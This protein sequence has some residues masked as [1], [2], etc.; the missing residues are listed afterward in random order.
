MQW[1][2]GDT[3]TIFET[4]E[5]GDNPFY[6]DYQVL[7]PSFAAIS[8]L[9][10]VEDVL[11]IIV[12]A[13]G[14][15]AHIRFTIV[16]WGH[17]FNMDPRALPFIEVDRNDVIQGIYSVSEEQLRAFARL[18][19]KKSYK[20]II[21]MS[22]DDVLLT[23]ADLEPLRRQ[24]EE[25]LRISTA[26]LEVSPLSGTNQ[27]V[28][29]DKALNLLYQPFLSEPIEKKEGI[30]IVGWKWPSRERKFDIGACLSLLIEIGVK[31]NYVIPGGSKVEDFR[32][33]LS[34]Q[35]NL[36]WCPAYIGETL[37]SLEREKGIPIAG[38]TPPYG[39]EGTMQWITELAD[40]LNDRDHLLLEAE[41]ARNRFIEE[42]KPIKEQLQ[43]K[44]GFVSGGPGRLP[45]LISIMADLGID[46]VAAALYWPHPSSRK[47]L[48][49]SLEKLPKLPQVFLV[50][51]SLYELDEIA[52]DLKPDFWMGGFQEQHACKR[53]G[54]PFIPTT[55]YTKSH[56]CFEGVPTVGRKII[57]VLN[58]FD[59]VAN[60]FQ[61]VE[62]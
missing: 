58:G 7:G 54:I 44:R 20:R 59:F 28:G 37:E 62:G 43:G 24:L 52:R 26:V 60:P 32:N 33:S 17:D 8:V 51:P 48:P 21:V 4:W 2:K 57:K 13:R 10:G 29:Y 34:S 1:Y 31:V 56:Q 22:N 16:A 5:F 38:Y 49:K 53:Y 36:L 9:L 19:E 11:P 47:V 46:I 45:G 30:N 23:S 12:A 15:A 50:G 55:V 18:I 35:V 25:R 40:A 41:K 61:T 3:K 27:W 42:V 14:C 6:A 39:F